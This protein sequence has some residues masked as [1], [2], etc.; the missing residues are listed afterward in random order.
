MDIEVAGFTIT[1]DEWRDLDE[2]TR[3]LLLDAAQELLEPQ[4]AQ[5]LEKRRVGDA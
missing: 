2:D 3:A 5:P 1:A 4:L